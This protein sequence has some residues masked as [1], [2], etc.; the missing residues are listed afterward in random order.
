[1]VM[2]AECSYGGVGRM[3]IWWCRQNVHM[4]VSAECSYGGVC[5]MFMYQIGTFT[6][7]NMTCN[8]VNK[9]AAIV[10]LH[11]YLNKSIYNV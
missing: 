7:Q 2:S 4:V 10:Y 6:Y 8:I 1:M 11:V 3:F 5:R 9:K